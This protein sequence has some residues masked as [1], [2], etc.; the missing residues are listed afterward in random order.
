V[1]STDPKVSATTSQGIR[2]YFSVIDI[3]NILMFFLTVHIA[4]ITSFVN[5]DV[6]KSVHY[7]RA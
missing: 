7:L 2:G 1:C 3:M 4:V 5:T 6:V